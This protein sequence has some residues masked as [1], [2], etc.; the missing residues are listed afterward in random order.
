MSTLILAS[1]VRTATWTEANVVLSNSACVGSPM[2][3]LQ[4]N[5]CLPTISTR[6]SSECD[7]ETGLI[8]M[9]SVK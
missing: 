4:A 1:K 6:Y 3:Q 2:G 9:V 5:V 8:I 7:S